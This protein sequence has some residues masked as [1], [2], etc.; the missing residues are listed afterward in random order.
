MTTRRGKR[1]Y[2]RFAALALAVTVGLAALGWIPTLRRA[3]AEALPSLVA[4]C[5]V[6]LAAA[7]VGGLVIHRADPASRL[8]GA[9]AQGPAAAQAMVAGLQAMGVR[10]LVLAG[11]GTAVGLANVVPLEPFLLWMVISYLALL[12][13]ETR[14]ALID[15]K[16]GTKRE[17]D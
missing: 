8:G 17:M 6:S 3:G 15:V 10:L 9:S 1:R 11:L 16:Q 14:F 2:L 7:L 5:A 12:P 4:G 13:V